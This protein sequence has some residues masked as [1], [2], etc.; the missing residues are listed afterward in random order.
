MVACYRGHVR[1]H[2]LTVLLLTPPMVQFNTPYAATPAL[3]A[4]LRARGV[5]VTQADLSL[6]L[7]LRLF[8]RRGLGE[9]LAALGPVSRRRPSHPAVAHFRAHAAAYRATVGEV[10]R[11]LQ[12]EP[13]DAHAAARGGRAGPPRRFAADAL[14]R[15]PR[16]AVLDDLAAAGID[17]RA[18]DP[19]GYPRLLASLYLDD[20]ADAVQQGVD[21]RFGLSRYAECLA[22]SAASF[23]PIRK[24][25]RAA[26]S[27]IDRLLDELTLRLLRRVKPDVIGITIPFPGNVYAAFRIARQAKAWNPGVRIVAGGGY[28]NTEL[29]SLSDPRVFDDVDFVTYDDG[30]LPLLRAIEHVAGRA[31]RETLIRTRLR[32]GRR[33]VFVDAEAPAIRH[34]DRPAPRYDGLPLDRYCGMAES[35]NPMHRLWTER[36]WMKLALAHGCYWHRCAFCDTGL[37]Y[38]ARYDPADPDTLVRWIADI[39]RRTGENHFHFVDEAAP[40]ALL[41]RLADALIRRRLRIR[42]WTNIRFEEAFTPDVAARLAESGCMAMTG[43]LECAQ[44]R[45]LA[46]MDKGVSLSGAARAMHALARAGILVHAY[47]MYGFPRQTI[48]ET[49]DALEFVRQ[50]FRAGIVH[51]AYWHRFALTVHS[52]VFAHPERF[53][54]RAVAPAGTFARNEVAFTDGRRTDHAR[55]GTALRRAVYNYMHGAG[56]DADVRAWFARR[57]PK[58]RLPARFVAAALAP[59]TRA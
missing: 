9:V 31:G 11:Y 20:L 32:V 12:H 59:E 57:A 1:Y 48:Q 56:L 22:L 53:G 43:G 7:A 30:E 16:F 54:V 17:P 14:P 42:W 40:P 23:A 39:Q 51:S 27:L 3:T 29:R 26:P 38:I 36:R 5:R 19:A 52:P 25:L 41:C 6:A 35:V 50:L 28:V 15:G 34:R 24:A 18:A 44:R 55:L 4:F 46:T 49:V 2:D 58:P 13:C 8:S 21:P 33:V 10:I 45:L 37:D 47:L